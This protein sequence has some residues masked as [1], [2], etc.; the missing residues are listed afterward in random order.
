MQKKKIG[1]GVWFFNSVTVLVLNIALKFFGTPPTERWSL[2]FLNLDGLFTA[3][4]NRMAG[5]RL[6]CLS[7]LGQKRPSSFTQFSEEG[8]TE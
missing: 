4:R 1:F 2:L 7:R 5:V 8:Y 6:Y 3:L